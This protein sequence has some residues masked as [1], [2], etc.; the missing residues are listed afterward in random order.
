MSREPQPSTGNGSV[1]LD[2]VFLDKVV[3]QAELKAIQAAFPGADENKLVGLA[4]SGGGI[5]SATFGLG[6]LEGLKNL[7][8]LNLLNQVHYLSTVSGGGYIGSWFSANCRRAADRGEGDWRSREADWSRSIQYLRDY[9]NYLSPEIGFFSADTWSMFTIWCRNA[10]LVQWTIAITVACVLLIPRLAAYVFGIWPMVGDFRWIS[11]A[12][13]IVSIIGIAANL[14]QVSTAKQNS[15]RKWLLQKEHAWAGLALATVFGAAA[16]ILSAAVGFDPFGPPPV[17]PCIALV[18]AGLLV[19]GGYCLLPAALAVYDWHTKLRYPEVNY[20]QTH[21]QW[22]IVVPL[23]VCSF[24][25]GAILWDLRNNV[26]GDRTTYG[27]LFLS[28]WRDWPFPLSVVF[29]SL[30]GLAFCSIEQW[31]VKGPAVALIAAVGSV[32]ALHALLC[33]IVLLLQP[34][35]IESTAHAFVAAPVMVLYA[36]SLTI[37]VLIGLVGRQSLEGVRE[38]WSR[39]GAWLI[40]YGAA[41]MI[42]T[43][44]AVYGPPLVYLAFREHF[45]VSLSSVSGWAGIILA[46]LAAGHSDRTGRDETPRARN[47]L[48]ELV[49]FVA[50]LL[51]IAGLLIGV[52][53]LLDLII[54]ANTRGMTWRDLRPG[55]AGPTIALVSLA[56]LGGCV[57]L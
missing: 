40:I 10:L 37:I 5:R 9:S 21:V 46:G 32:V 42:G 1:T 34:W 45:W 23:L 50:P 13:F 18:V 28:A 16:W 4:F 3:W 14:Q 22:F 12:L 35:S 53:T 41:W 15:W 48:H 56:M 54:Q 2:K 49:A 36:F 7:K 39:L 47:P 26:L 25:F 38:W 52:A 29:V 30:W 8:K 44:V 43:V 57:G 33:A 27:A 24:F 55:A 20:G 11:V 31:K 17:N 19:V 51:F 6:V